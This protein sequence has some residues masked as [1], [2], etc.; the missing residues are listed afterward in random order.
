MPAR[1]LAPAYASLTCLGWQAAQVQRIVEPARR[2]IRSQI[3]PA[4]GITDPSEL[5]S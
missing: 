3:E 5:A 2:P 4:L 1:W